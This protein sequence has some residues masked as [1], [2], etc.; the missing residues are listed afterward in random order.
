MKKN[1]KIILLLILVFCSIIVLAGCANSND[2]LKKIKNITDKTIISD[3]DSLETN[4]LIKYNAPK[5]LLVNFDSKI[6][7]WES[8]AKQSFY[9]ISINGVV[10]Y[11]IAGFPYFA[12][13]DLIEGNTYYIKVRIKGNELTHTDSE[14]SDIFVYTPEKVQNGRPLSTPQNL[15]IEKNVNGNLILKWDSAYNALWYSICFNGYAFNYVSGTEFLLTGWDTDI[16]V[17]IKIKALGDSVLFADSNWTDVIN[18]SSYD[19]NKHFNI[20]GI[21]IKYEFLL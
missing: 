18:Y 20:L 16:D 8:E 2:N 3:T 7:L 1:N 10:H 11:G 5:N 12:L 4:K 6:L 13:W 21:D 15:R 17:N 19:Q 9:D 14:W